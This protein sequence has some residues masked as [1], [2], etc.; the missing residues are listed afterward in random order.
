MAEETGPV[1]PARYTDE[2]LAEI[3]VDGGPPRLSGPVVLVDY[4]ESWPR[5]YE[6]EAE[7]IRD[8]LGP[9]VLLIEH[10]G[11]T[12]VPGLA[13]KPIIDIDL[14]VA[15]SGDEAAYLPALQAAG[16]RL[17][18]REPDWYQHRVLKG[19]GTN[20]NLHVFSAGCPEVERM[21]AFRDWLRAHDADRDLYARTKRQLAGREWTYVQNYADAK[22]HV[23]TDIMRRATAP[24]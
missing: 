21:V 5:L 19:P 22:T 23:V 2:Q 11:S 12:S 7:R 10:V 20:V 16:Y 17:V 13:A 15:D 9:R 3:W 6:R 1:K 8:V 14:V 18:I 4:D 24:G